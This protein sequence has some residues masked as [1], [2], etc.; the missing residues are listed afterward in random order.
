MPT[1]LLDLEPAA[2]HSVPP[3]HVKRGSALDRADENSREQ[4]RQ[5]EKNAEDAA[6]RVEA[7][8]SALEAR[9]IRLEHITAKANQLRVRIRAVEAHDFA[10]QLKNC[11]DIFDRLFC[12]PA[13]SEP[14]NAHTL[15]SATAALAWLPEA[16]KRQGKLA[17]KLKIEL[18]G[19][20]KE[21]EALNRK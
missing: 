20:E 11:E 4:L 21:L 15:N 5:A 6:L 17:E 18:A 9:Q 14:N 10:G 12:S 1:A 16:M 13:L 8:R 3:P 19:A 7:E 2:D